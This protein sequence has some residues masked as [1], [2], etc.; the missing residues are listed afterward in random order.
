MGK[1]FSALV[2]GAGLVLAAPVW[3]QDTARERGW[4]L[5]ANVLEVESS[6]GKQPFRFEDEE[7]G[8]A[9]AGSY[10]F[11]KHFALQGAYY[12]LGQHFVTDCPA[13]IC[14]AVPHEDLA[15]IR[16][17]SVAA[18]GSWRVAP[19]VEIFGKLGVLASETDF[20]LSGYEDTDRGAL[21]GAGVGIWATPRWRI[22]V[23]VERADFDLESAGV[24]MT[25]RF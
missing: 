5:E 23:Q 20:E 21:V 18:V 3:S 6:E 11:A 15:D 8:V 9:I 22:N 13:P 14:T 17:L 4:S 1:Q 2:I 7:T 12:D 24:G 10:A 25:Y 19:A 16:G